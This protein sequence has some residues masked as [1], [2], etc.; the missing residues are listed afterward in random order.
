[1]CL[2][3]QDEIVKVIREIF[4]RTTTAAEIDPENPVDNPDVKELPE[5]FMLYLGIWNMNLS[6][7]NFSPRE[8]L[9]E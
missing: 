1:M 3:H 7:F 2:F 6:I 9:Y 8:F 4:D 5:S